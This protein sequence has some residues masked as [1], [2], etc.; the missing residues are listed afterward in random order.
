[1][2]PPSI[3]IAIFRRVAL[4]AFALVASGGLFAEEDRNGSYIL[5][6]NDQV[7]LSVYE[8]PELSVQVK[9]LKTGQAS[10]PLIG[11][12]NIGGLSVVKATEVIRELYDRDY[13]IDPKLTLSVDEYTTEF[14]SVVGQVKQPGQFAIPQSGH[15]DLGSAL[16]TAGG[17]TPEADISNIQLVRAS[18]GSTTYTLAAIQGSAGRIR[19]GAGDRVVVQ[20][21]RFVRRHVTVLGQVGKPGAVTFPVDGRLDLVTA[22]ALAGGLADLANPRKVSINRKGKVTV[23]DFREISERSGQPYLLDPD[24]IITVSERLF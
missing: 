24:D 2:I 14:I 13:L 16:A 18:G 23:V 4:T 3:F 10:F 5:R 6:P 7:S 19:L 11:A 12:V 9:I 17:T 21:S 8:E 1:M 20:E 22:V 15:L